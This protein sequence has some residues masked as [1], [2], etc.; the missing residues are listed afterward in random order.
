MKTLCTQCGGYNL[1]WYKQL[2]QSDQQESGQTNGVGVQ[3]VLSCDDCSCTLDR[4]LG[5]SVAEQLN[6]QL[7]EIKSLRELVATCYAGLGAECNLPVEWLDVLNQAANGQKFSVVN[8]L[9]FNRKTDWIN[10]SLMDCEA[11]KNKAWN[12]ASDP[13][14]KMEESS[15]ALKD[16]ALAISYLQEKFAKLSHDLIFESA[17]VAEQKLRADQITLQ[18]TMQAKMHAQALKELVKLR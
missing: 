13:D 6:C 14:A 9:P 5:C 18:H 3:F 7:A 16:C 17:R 4:I 1:S 15:V 8:L 12:I 11:I 10:G 2:I